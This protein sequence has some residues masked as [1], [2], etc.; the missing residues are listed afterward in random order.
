MIKASSNRKSPP[1][2]RRGQSRLPAE[3]VPVIVGAIAGRYL[4]IERYGLLLLLHSVR[5]TVGRIQICRYRMIAIVITA[6][7]IGVC[8]LWQC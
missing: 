1:E 3:I 5:I 8:W 6:Q 4:I 2:S 7:V